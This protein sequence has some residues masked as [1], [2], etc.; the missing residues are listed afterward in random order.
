VPRLF[1]SAAVGAGLAELRA[2]IA[3]ASIDA[4][5]AGDAMPEDP[6]FRPIAS[7]EPEDIY[8]P[9]EPLPDDLLEAAPDEASD[10][11]HV[12]E[13]RSRPRAA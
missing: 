8:G 11:A 5:A 12:D 1:I 7:D 10:V 9:T 13:H 3:Q 2:A 4:D 6:R